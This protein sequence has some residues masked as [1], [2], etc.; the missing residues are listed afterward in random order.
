M[1]HP[2]IMQQY[3]EKGWVVVD[4]VFGA[5]E[6]ERIRD[7]AMEISMTELSGE[8]GA[9]LAD[10][11]ADGKLA[12]RKVDHPYFKTAEF[13]R[14]VNDPRLQDLLREFL[15]GE[16]RLA[17]DQ[18]FMKPPHFGSAKP[19]HQDNAYFKISP[20]DQVITAWIALDDVDES[21][22]CLRYIDGSHLGEIVPHEPIPGEAFNLA[23][24]EELIDLGKESLA[25]VKAG[26][27]VFH[28]GQA[29]HTSHRNESDRWRRAYAT[30]WV[31]PDVTSESAILDGVYFKELPV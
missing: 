15:G 11:D 16:P 14:F 7:L 12:P 23:P 13:R 26:G 27:V 10:S 8:H 21:N 9:Y 2:E 29:L 24:P 31:G 25:I 3:R 19:Y 18:I 4:G 30:H 22:G 28:H 1:L 17:E 5:E 20:R 6:I